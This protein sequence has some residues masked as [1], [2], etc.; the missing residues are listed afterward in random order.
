MIAHNPV[1]SVKVKGQSQDLPMVLNAVI[2][3]IAKVVDMAEPVGDG[4]DLQLAV[5]DEGRL[6]LVA[7]PPI[8]PKA[9]AADTL[10]VTLIIEKAAGLSPEQTAAILRAAQR[11]P[12]T[13]SELQTLRSQMP[14][15]TGLPMLLPP[16]CLS[17]IA[18]V[19]TVHHM[20]DF[21]MLVEAVQAMGVPPQ[22]IT[23][24]D[25]GYRYPL[26]HR[27]DAHLSA[28]GITVW[29]W[30]RTADALG[31]HAQRASALGRRGLLIDDGGYTL[32]VLLA[33]RPELI[34]QFV[35]LVE[36]TI[37]GITKLEPWAD[38]LPVPI[39]SVAESA[40]KATIESYGIADAAVR[41]V[42]ALLP[43][44][45]FEGQ[46][47][48][49]IGFGRIGEQIAHV[50]R[51]RRMRVAVHDQRMVRLLAAHEHGFFTSRFLSQLLREHRPLLIIGAT[52]RTS[53]RGEHTAAI[54]RDCYLV[55]TTSRDREFAVEELRRQSSHVADLGVL[56]TQLSLPSGVQVTVVG[57]GYPINFHHSQSLPNKYSDLILASLLVG[58]AT[59]AAPEH[60]FARGHNVAASDQ[61][62]ESCGLLERY[63][64][65]FGPEAT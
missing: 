42:L 14:L 64:A 10:T 15:T 50:L 3:S 11:V 57:D 31:D 27:V 35:G 36:Q 28:E 20:T 44:E 7:G 56:G 8:D 38:H 41:N 23:V 37:S 16:D 43:E 52:G 2:E 53:L 4:H 49:V 19:L 60:G 17:T 18:P 29:P 62:L 47:A 30:E 26:T 39:F 5:G 51:T 45:K 48:L 33:D 58:A 34:S 55:S 6:R 22:A 63:Y 65:R 24:I 32:P 1:A 21:L 25:K 12:F 13:G 59:L 40:V 61:V 46:S 54:I 9:E